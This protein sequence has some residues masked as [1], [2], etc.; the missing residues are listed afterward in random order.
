VNRARLILALTLACLLFAS[1]SG[2]VK[3]KADISAYG[4]TP[5][6]ISGLA[7]A[8]FR[9]TPNDLAKLECVQMSGSG[10]T[11]KA[12]TVSAVG[13]LLETFLAHYGKSMSDFS[14]IRFY[15]SDQYK[16]TL[17]D[18]Y[19]TNYKIVLSIAKGKDPLPANEQPCRLFIPKAESSNW[20]YS[21]IRIEFIAKEQ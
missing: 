11:E 16:I 21:I 13:P 17:K 15:A 4:D 2:S 1:C 10:K 19:L 18:E 3:V 7:N 8:D 6:T 9:V 14:K 20:I 12:G 5:I